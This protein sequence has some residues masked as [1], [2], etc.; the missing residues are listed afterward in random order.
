MAACGASNTPHR[1]GAKL[2]PDVPANP[3]KFLLTLVT[4]PAIDITRGPGMLQDI[5]TRASPSKTWPA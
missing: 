4:T 3:R 1:P 2:P 5:C